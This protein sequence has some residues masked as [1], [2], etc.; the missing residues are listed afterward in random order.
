MSPTGIPGCFRGMEPRARDGGRM[1][2]ESFSY[3]IRRVSSRQ[4]SNSPFVVSGGKS[5]YHG[6]QNG[7]TA[8]KCKVTELHC[9]CTLNS[10][11]T[12]TLTAST[13]ICFELAAQCTRLHSLALSN[14]T[15]FSSK[16]SLDTDSTQ[17]RVR[18]M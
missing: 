4:F 7:G 1:N 11:H 6:F 9:L 10:V 12:S 16:F 13:S 3:L 17:P 2:A 18:L 8:T 14:E 15:V 5:W